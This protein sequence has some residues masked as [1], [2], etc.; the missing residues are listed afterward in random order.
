M[1]V[2][3]IYKLRII[4]ILFLLFLGTVALK[5]K[6][7]NMPDQLGQRDGIA[8]AEQILSMYVTPNLPPESAFVMPNWGTYILQTQN[9]K[10]IRKIEISS[11]IA[12]S[13]YDRAVSNYAYDYGI[14]DFYFTYLNDLYYSATTFEE[15]SYLTGM[16]SGYSMRM[17]NVQPVDLPQNP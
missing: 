9:G 2:Y 1:L 6:A 3:L 15:S 10:I 11:G 4:K 8:F 12:A 7:Q 17:S 5:S 13:W 14:F 16:L